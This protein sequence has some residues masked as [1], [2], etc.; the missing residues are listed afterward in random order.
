MATHAIGTGTA[1]L[2][3]N[4]PVDERDF[5]GRL[6]F[7]AI[8]RG[9]AKSVGDFQRQVLANGLEA[10]DPERSLH[11]REI[12]TRYYSGALAALMIAASVLTWFGHS[13]AEP[14][15]RRVSA[16]RAVRIGRSRFETEA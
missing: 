15:V 3:I 1:N 14:M 5:W 4:V 12:R 7:Q 9:E 16:A 2:S 6:A 13:T 10:M 11:L 8:E